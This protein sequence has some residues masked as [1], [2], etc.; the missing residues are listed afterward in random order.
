MA[1]THPLYWAGP[2]ETAS[3]E[4]LRAHQ[5]AR[6]APLVDW[7]G[8]RC[9][10]WRRTFDEIGV[11]PADIRTLEDLAALP[12]ITKAIY[13]RNMDANPPYGDFLCYPEEEIHRM[14][15]IVYRTTGTTGKQR[16]F[17]NTH[18]GY[19]H[20]GDQGIRNL[21]CAG[22]RPGEIVMSILPLSLWSAGWGFY[23]G[24]R[25]AGM[26][27]LAAGP[28]YDTRMRLDLIRDYRPAAICLTPSY[29]LTLA[30]AAEANGIDIASFG[31]RMLSM[32]GE[33]FPESRRRKIEQLWG[34]PGGARDFSGITEGGP[35]YMGSE[36]DAQAGE[37]LYEDE[38]IFEFVEI[39]GNK[40]VGP[41]EMG[42][43]V[44]TSLEQRV[45]GTSFHYRTGD[46]VRYTEDVCTCG[47]TH[48]RINGIEGRVDD[49]VKVRGI[50]IF[51]SAIEEIIR[52]VAGL[53]D[54]FVLVLERGAAGDEVTV[55][56]EPAPGL[57]AGQYDDAGGALEA[58]LRR[59]MT[60]R[61][62]VRIAEPGSLPRF[63]LKAQRWIDRRPKEE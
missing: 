49:M 45:M 53:A 39:G 31:V 9:P 44:F 41:G 38:A 1:E 43:L 12:Y 15:A 25:K 30:S 59:A 37:H 36:C 17:I 28:P 57:E 47:R 13:A 46:I 6:L 42:E 56:V 29:A 5:E 54:D 11:A 35:L 22:I 24:C 34:I 18:E 8:A 14:G 48:R 51:P 21:W 50:N 55:E 62:P 2:I 40:P 26:T 10:F 61:I 52:N 7:L 16:W 3:R 4:E 33:P 20:F 19:Q 32:G 63:E 23:Y 60:I 27:Y 58:E